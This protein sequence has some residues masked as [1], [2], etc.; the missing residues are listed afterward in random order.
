VHR[1]LMPII[2]QQDATMINFFIFLHT[3]LHVS[4]DTFTHQQEHT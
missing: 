2:V 1:E 4:G 3:A